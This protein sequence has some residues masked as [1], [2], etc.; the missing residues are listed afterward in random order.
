L[1]S[2]KSVLAAYT[3]A[4][5]NHTLSTRGVSLTTRRYPVRMPD[6]EPLIL[7]LRGLPQSFPTNTE[8]EFYNNTKQLPPSFNTTCSSSP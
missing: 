7:T 4:H 5:K 1:L 2:K 3:H 6:V 8:T